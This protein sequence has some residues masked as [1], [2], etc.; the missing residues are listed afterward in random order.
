MAIQILEKTSSR[1]QISFIIQGLE[2]SVDQV[3]QKY[4][5]ML[6]NIEGFG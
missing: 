5:K 6:Q 3:Q 2:E 1:D 4:D